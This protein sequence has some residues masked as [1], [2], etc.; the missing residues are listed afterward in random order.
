MYD[1]PVWLLT[2]TL[3]TCPVIDGNVPCKTQETVT[4]SYSAEEYC[5]RVRINLMNQNNRI[6]KSMCEGRYADGSIA[7][8]ALTKEDKQL[9]CTN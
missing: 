9:K 2:A 3:L 6:V 4:Y 1:Y 5:E 8:S 7:A